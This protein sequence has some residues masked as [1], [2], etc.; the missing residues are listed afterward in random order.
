MSKLS[1]LIA[2]GLAPNKACAI[3]GDVQDFVIAGGTTQDEATKISGDLVVVIAATEGSG[4][5]LSSSPISPKDSTIIAN[6]SECEVIVYP[7]V[8][9]TINTLAVNAGFSVPSGKI[10]FVIARQDTSKYVAGIT[11]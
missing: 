6:F 4:V 7:P 1:K 11:A 2:A 10:A 9:G 8:G 3:N 5:I